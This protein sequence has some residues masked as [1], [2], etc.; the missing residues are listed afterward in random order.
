MAA[1]VL[2]SSPAF[3]DDDGFSKATK[4]FQKISTALTGTL[5]I[6]TL[7]V[8]TCWVGYKVMWDGRSL[9]DFK[10]IIIGAICIGG[11]SGLASYLLAN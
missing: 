9:G 1:A 10:N 5:A 8:A 7:T 11:A 3:A 2:L 6:A 4:L